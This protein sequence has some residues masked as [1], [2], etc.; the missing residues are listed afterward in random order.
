LTALVFSLTDGRG[1]SRLVLFHGCADAKRSVLPPAGQGISAAKS[2]VNPVP[3][4]HRRFPRLSLGFCGAG[5]IEKP[6]DLTA[7]VFSLTD[8]RTL[9]DWF[10]FLGVMTRSAP[11]CLRRDKGLPR[12]SPLSIPCRLDTRGF[13]DLPWA[14]AGLVKSRNRTI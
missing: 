6:D 10:Y 5:Q 11:V 3:L 1:V 13:Q 12:Q 9:A 14:F 2:L 7:L 8:G 4:G